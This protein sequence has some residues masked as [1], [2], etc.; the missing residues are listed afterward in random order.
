MITKGDCDNGDILWS[1]TGVP[2]EYYPFP[3][4]G[5][6]KVTEGTTVWLSAVP[7]AGYEF[8]TWYGDITPGDPN[9]YKFDGTESIDVS[10]LFY[11]EGTEGDDYIVIEVGDCDNGEILWSVDGENFYP[12]PPSGELYV[13]KG[14]KV[15][16]KAVPD[17][18]YEFIHWI[19]DIDP[20][21][22]NPY[23]FDSSESVKIGAVFGIWH[24]VGVNSK[25]AGTFKYTITAKDPITG[26]DFVLDSGTF[27][28]GRGGGTKDLR[29]PN[30][31]SLKVEVTSDVKGSVEWDDGN[32]LT[33]Q[34]GPVYARTVNS[35]MQ[36]EA[37]FL[38]GGGGGI[39][40]WWILLAALAASA[41]FFLIPVARNKPRIIGKVTYNDNGIPNV[42]IEYTITMKNDDGFN[43]EPPVRYVVTN[44]KGEYVIYVTMGATVEILSV[45]KGRFRTSE[46]L[47]TEI[48]IEERVTEKDYTM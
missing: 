3:A 39:G 44:P 47:P 6:L 43:G 40:P 38:G 1:L 13:T 23:V 8:S 41:F 27:S 22:D 10:A 24:T 46:E 11:K 30:G 35:G 32:P 15:W 36:I 16:L 19:G 31:A 34:F 26:E 29:V 42:K 14:K 7:D 48:V 21:A 25:G 33:R 17:P 5:E 12:F 9:P 18:G 4:S 2:G 28:F 37:V 20:K 45:A